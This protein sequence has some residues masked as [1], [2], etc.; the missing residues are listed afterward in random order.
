MSRAVYVPL[1][2]GVL[3][4]LVAPALTRRLSPRLA[5]WTL[6]ITAMFVATASLA[7]LG[8]LAWLLVAELPPVAGLGRWQA[9]AVASASPVPPEV[10][11]AALAVLAWTAWRVARRVAA[12]MGEARLVLSL[13]RRLPSRH[14]PARLVVVDDPVPSAHALAGLP[15]CGGHIVVSTG[16]LR[17]LGD[18]D[19]RHAV[20]AHERAHLRH[21]HATIRVVVDLARAVNPLLRRVSRE[22]GFLL[23]RWADEEAAAA[24]S[25]ATAAEALA[26]VSLASAPARRRLAF[27]TLGVPARVAALLDH[28]MV[29]PRRAAA[30]WIALGASLAVSAVAILHA[31]HETEAFFETI[32]SWK[33]LRS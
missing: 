9:G 31:C 8:L 5:V 33:Q 1:L 23:E 13:E 6:M 19:L 10:A 20:L 27:H 26:T 29:S 15:R 30:V 32:R 21:H 24:T 17:A 14:G 2:V 4:A 25:R 7:S 16:I 11:A 3:A 18:T 22:V 12:V 28:P